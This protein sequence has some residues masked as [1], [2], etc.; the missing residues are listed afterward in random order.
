MTV[1]QD[2]WVLTEVEE[3]ELSESSIEVISKGLE[4]GQKLGGDLWLL[5]TGLNSEDIPDNIACSGAARIYILAAP[6]S[7]SYLPDFY[8]KSILALIDS[9]K[10][11]FILSASSNLGNEIMTELAVNIKAGIVKDCVSVDVDEK[12]L[13][14]YTKPL[15]GNKVY[16]T[17]SCQNCD[18]QMATLKTGS[19]STKKPSAGSRAE[20]TTIS[21]GIDYETEVKRGEFIKGDPATI[22]ISEAE[23]IVAGG[24]GVGNADNFKIL[25]DLAAALGGTVGVSMVPVDE[26]WVSK[27]KMIGQTGVSVSPKLYIACGISGASHH[28]LGIKDSRNIISVNI[29]KYAPIFKVTDIKITADLLEIIPVITRKL[30]E[31]KALDTK[32]DNGIERN[33]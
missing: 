9:Q 11:R 29:D 13:F 12:G 16:G 22:D 28:V 4:I 31:R 18:I 27:K 30:K 21:P 15:Y 5:L 19:A 26:D 6:D 20:I 33:G 1:S 25:E 3:G 8:E 24:R 10:P 7:S 2:V 17:I 32:N 14:I 23:I